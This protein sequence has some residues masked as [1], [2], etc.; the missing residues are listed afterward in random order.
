MYDNQ[1][2][3]AGSTTTG[4]VQAVPTPHSE[5]RQRLTGQIDRLEKAEALL[6]EKL[7]SVLLPTDPPDGNAELAEIESEASEST[8]SLRKDADRITVL[9]R[10]IEAVTARIDL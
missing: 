10:R 2:I 8:E 4:Y 6:R 3:A 1:I 7:Q 9:C 5:A